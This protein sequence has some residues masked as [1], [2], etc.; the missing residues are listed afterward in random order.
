MRLEVGETKNDEGRT[1][2]LDE[3][4]KKVFSGQWKQQEKIKKLS[5]Y[6]FPERDGIGKIGNY[7][8]AWRNASQ[9]SG[10]GKHLFHDF[11]RTAVRD[12]IRAGLPKRVAMLVSGH[13]T[14]TIFDRYNIVND[15][16][17]RLAASQ[18]EA[19]QQRQMGTVTGTIINLNEKRFIAKTANPLFQHHIFKLGWEDSNLLKPTTNN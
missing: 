9:N 1:I 5:P 19:Y 18:R 6:V 15:T 16:E 17:L 13:K 10:I 12:M 3:E 14:R 4:L 11:R 2:Y 7:Q 8:R